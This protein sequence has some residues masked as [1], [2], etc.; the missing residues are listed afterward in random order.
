MYQKMEKIKV[1]EIKDINWIHTINL[2]YHIELKLSDISGFFLI[3]YCS[4]KLKRSLFAARY[5]LT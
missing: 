3:V 2:I 1:M 4:Y 5:L